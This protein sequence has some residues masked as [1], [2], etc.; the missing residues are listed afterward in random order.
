MDRLRAGKLEVLIA[1]DLASRGLDV[2]G[3]THIINYDLPDDPE[4]YVHRIG[5]TARAGRKGTAWSLVTPDQG[6]LLSD[7]EKLTSTHIEKLEYGDFKPKEKPADWTDEP[8]GGRPE[9]KLPPPLA[10]EGPDFTDPNLFPGGIVPS[11]DAKKT[12]GGRFKRRRR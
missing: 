9:H 2:E 5:R 4:V 10:E 12:L 1:S 8:T 11:G 3:I 6:Q 7:I